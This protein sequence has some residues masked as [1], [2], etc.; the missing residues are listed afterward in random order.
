MV[1]FENYFAQ[2]I[3]TTRGCV[4]G[5]NHINRSEVKVTGGSQGH[6][7]HLMFFAFQNRVQPITSSCKVEFENFLAQMIITTR[8]CVMCK[9]HVARSK[10]KV[11]VCTYSL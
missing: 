7:W 3:I 4:S 8:Q 11:T 6:R 9:N 2:T 10:V 5:K 1:G